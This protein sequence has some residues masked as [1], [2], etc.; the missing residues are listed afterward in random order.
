[1]NIKFPIWWRMSIHLRMAEDQILH[2]NCATQVSFKVE[3]IIHMT[4]LGFLKA[5]DNIRDVKLC[6]WTRRSC[7][8]GCFLLIL[9]KN[10]PTHPN[11]ERYAAN[12]CQ[13]LHQVQ[14]L[15]RSQTQHVPDW[16]AFQ[17]TKVIMEIMLLNFT[18]FNFSTPT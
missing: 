9:S 6:T 3:E 15:L 18:A 14:P 13:S 5:H 17:S 2:I 8:C 4:S 7:C 10:P 12:E 16:K 11:K 1:M